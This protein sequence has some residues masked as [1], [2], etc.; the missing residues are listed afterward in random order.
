L[1]RDTQERVTQNVKKTEMKLNAITVGDV[2]YAIDKKTLR[3]YD[4]A[5][6]LRA[7]EGKGELLDIGVFDVRTQVVLFDK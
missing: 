3:V 4:Y 7:K 2:K 6:Y 1:E 5:S